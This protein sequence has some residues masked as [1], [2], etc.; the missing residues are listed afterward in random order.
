MWPY[1]WFI[2]FLYIFYLFYFFIDFGLWCLPYPLVYSPLRKKK[3]EYIIWIN[4]MVIIT[5]LRSFIIKLRMTVFHIAPKCTSHFLVDLTCGK[6]GNMTIDIRFDIRCIMSLSD[7][8]IVWQIFHVSK[9]CFFY[10]LL[11]SLCWFFCHNV[12]IFLQYHI[13]FYIYNWAMCWFWSALV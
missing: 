7:L 12:E 3:D 6:I 2:M 10:L 5:K 8:I 11:A 1:K 9:N 13:F 4:I